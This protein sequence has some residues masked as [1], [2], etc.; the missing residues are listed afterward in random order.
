MVPRR[1]HVRH[2]P[3]RGVLTE[4]MI[5]VEEHI[6]KLGASGILVLATESD[7]SASGHF[8]ST[9]QTL[10]CRIGGQPHRVTVVSSH[11]VY[12]SGTAYDVQDTKPISEAEYASLQQ[13]HA[14]VDTPATHARIARRD[15]IRDQLDALTPKCP[16]CTLPMKQQ[17]GRHGDFWSCRSYPSCKGTRRWDNDLAARMSA[18]SDALRTT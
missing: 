10:A 14:T 6:K 3:S 2:R 18:L 7:E 4:C 15:A 9:T 16:K 8:E 11:N 5:P 1:C 13:H 12:K 17:S